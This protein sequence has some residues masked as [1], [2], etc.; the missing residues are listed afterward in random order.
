MATT[1]NWRESAAINLEQLFTAIAK[2]TTY[3]VRFHNNTKGLVI[4]SNVAHAA[5]QLR[6]SEMAE[7]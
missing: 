3:G 5:Q 2:A 6:G 7:A 4:T 1:F